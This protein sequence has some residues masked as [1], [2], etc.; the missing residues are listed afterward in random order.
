MPIIK[1]GDS[2]DLKQEC[3]DLVKNPNTDLSVFDKK[4]LIETVRQLNKMSGYHN[5]IGTLG[6]K[7]MAPYICFEP[8]TQEALAARIGLGKDPVEN[9]N[10]IYIDAYTRGLQ[11]SPENA[12]R[13]NPV[14]FLQIALET[15]PILEPRIS[16][17]SS[18][19]KI[20]EHIEK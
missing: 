10:D 1:K 19:E 3:V 7:N 5:I 20:L 9:S 6:N 13:T 17:G 8:K 12:S 11:F 18:E 16:A 2:C 15:L 14:K 4:D